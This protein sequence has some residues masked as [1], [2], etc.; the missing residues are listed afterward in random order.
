MSKQEVETK[1]KPTVEKFQA[2]A[3]AS[4]LIDTCHTEWS[5]I[6]FKGGYGIVIKGRKPN[7]NKAQWGAT[8]WRTDF[9][10]TDIPGEVAKK[11]TSVER[12]FS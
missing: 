12:M 11:L 1:M 3:E 9:D 7:G 5:S 8:L 6:L 2:V 4:K 10:I